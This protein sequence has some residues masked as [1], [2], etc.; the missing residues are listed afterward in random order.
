MTR[1]ISKDKEVIDLKATIDRIASGKKF[2]HRNDGAIFKN[3][4]GLLPAKHDG[5]YKEESNM[6][7]NYLTPTYQYFF[8]LDDH[9]Y[10]SF[11]VRIP[12]GIKT[13]DE[14]FS[15]LSEKLNFPEHFGRNWDALYDLLRDFSWICQHTI[16]MAHTD[17]PLAQ[18]ALQRTYLEILKDSVSDWKPGEKHRLVV[19]FPSSL[20]E[21]IAALIS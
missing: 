8:F 4:E 15:I 18:P 13:R 6:K 3:R 7:T 11:F 12:A 21:K 10:D 2:H 19:T 20:E 17:M 16:I 9:I 1:F 14:L 5:Y